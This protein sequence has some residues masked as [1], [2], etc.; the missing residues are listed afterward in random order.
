[1]IP[2]GTIKDRWARS[3][4]AWAQNHQG[5]SKPTPK[6][7]LKRQ[8]GEKWVESLKEAWGKDV[9]FD[10][11]GYSWVYQQGK[12]LSWGAG[13]WGARDRPCNFWVSL[14]GQPP[15]TIGRKWWWWWWSSLLSLWKVEGRCGRRSH[16]SVGSS[17]VVG[18]RCWRGRTGGRYSGYANWG[19]QGTSRS[20]VC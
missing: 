19:K 11:V 14:H 18:L 13:D 17:C 1:M 4:C 16:G 3:F 15:Q 7:P 10:G 5:G 8:L 6:W 20:L 12:H 9:M 2:G